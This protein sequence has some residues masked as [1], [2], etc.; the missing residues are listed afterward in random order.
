MDA[1]VG[2]IGLGTM[3]SMAAWQLA[4]Q[5][6]SVIG[7]EKF[8][9]GHD[10][11][12]AGGE[13]R[14]FR[15]A[16]K[17]SPEY[18][19]L[20]EDAYEL[21]RELENES[22]DQLLHLTKGLTIAPPDSEYVSNIWK[23]IEKFDLRHQVL[24]QDQAD[25]MYP[26]HKLNPED[27]VIVDSKS[28]FLKSQRSIVSAINRAE[29]LGAE[30]LDYSSV[31]NISQKN[32]K[33]DIK[34]GSKTYSV[35]KLLITAGPWSKEFIPK[36]KNHLKV[37]R[38][39]NAWF[40]PKSGVFSPDF[41]PV[42]NRSHQE[43]SY[44]GVPANDGEMIKLGIHGDK[45]TLEFP[46][47]LNKNISV[48][49][50]IKFSELVKRHLPDLNTTPSRMEAYMDIFTDDGNPIIG[51]LDNDNK[52]LGMTGFS[53]HGFK[54]APVIGKIGADLLTNNRVDYNVI[55]HCTPSRFV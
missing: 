30:I 21:W 27:V 37:Q 4:K 29:N 43:G 2:I 15:T 14:I 47:D 13:S 23:S 44:Y 45:S 7:F 24:N 48:K 19:P 35:N 54:M 40:L 25:Q 12:A 46:E 53:G 55:K 20:L 50:E 3:G 5:G 38:L 42:F 32:N 9:I 22:G 6:I 39:L 18:V 26:Q 16:Y 17:E 49:E 36:L 31:E 1:Q 28:G 51:F 8:G 34:V 11:S 41:F 52:I 10:R 33:I